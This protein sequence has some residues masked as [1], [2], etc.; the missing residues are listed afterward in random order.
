YGLLQPA[1][2]QNQSQQQEPVKV[3]LALS[4]GG[5]KGFA[6]IGVLK[7]LE[8]TDIQIDAIS[9]TSMGSIVGG[10]YS[11]GYSADQLEDIALNNNWMKLFSRRS[12]YR[13]QTIYQKEYLDNNLLTLPFSEGS[14]HL[15]RGLVQGHNVAM[16]LYRLTLPYHSIQDFTKLPIPFAAVATNLA[17]GEGVY[18]DHGY[19]PEVMRASIAIPTI[20]EPVKIDTSSYIDGGVARNIP[21]SDVQRLGAD[22]VIT[23][24]VSGPLSPVDSLNSFISIMQQ[25]VGFQMEA[26]NEHQLTLTD[27]HIRP[28]VKKYSSSDFDKAKKFIALGEKAAREMLPELKQLADSIRQEPRNE[29]PNFSIADSVLINQVNIDGGN[30][31]LRDRLKQSLQ[32]SIPSRQPTAELEKKLNKIYQTSS[33]K[34]LR[35]RLQKIPDHGGYALNIHIS[36]DTRQSVGISL[37]YDSQYKASLLFSGHFNQLFTPGDVLFANFR[38][39]KQ[40]KL[41][42]SYILPLY[43]YPKTD[44]ELK[45]TATRTPIDLFNEEQ[46]ISSIDLERLSL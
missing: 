17:T 31:Y 34:D 5:A 20:F 19:L 33:L 40:L 12:S 3:G 37:R 38:L 41:Q 16:L 32:I 11:L 18:L 25:A 13:H 2:A 26:S 46:R 24:D 6:H 7:V 36:A 21:A 42:G 15:P 1:H 44:F 39:G 10:L 30:P 28:D 45:A 27:V 35:Y 4:G 29:R 8:K 9:G 14:V 43:F 22:I 23:S